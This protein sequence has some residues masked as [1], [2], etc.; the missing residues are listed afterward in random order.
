MH[1]MTKMTAIPA[2]VKAIVAQRDCAHGP[3]TCIICGAPG[4]PHCHI[5]RR[6]QGGMGVEQNIVTLC[7]PC[8]YALDEGLF[9]DR[10]RP[11]RSPHGERGLKSP[12]AAPPGP[13]PGSLPA[14]G[15]WVEILWEG[16]RFQKRSVA[17]RMGSVG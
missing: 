7:G 4:G 16:S 14:R 11:R 17:P 1:H 8:H 12:T 5:I 9:L 3:A 6:S 2:K 13:W 10:L 15:A